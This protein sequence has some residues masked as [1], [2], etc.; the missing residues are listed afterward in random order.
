MQS[1]I[2]ASGNGTSSRFNFETPTLMERIKKST[3]VRVAAALEVVEEDYPFKWTD[4]PVQRFVCLERTWSKKKP[5]L[6]K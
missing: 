5:P 6:K 4:D 2:F 1:S 3:P